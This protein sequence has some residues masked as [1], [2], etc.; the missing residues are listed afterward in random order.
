MAAIEEQNVFS[1]SVE[2]QHTNPVQLSATTF[3]VKL[4][5]A[6]IDSLHTDD[7]D[8]LTLAALETEL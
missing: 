3:I 6:T 1:F 5:K 7:V 4:L 8:I 2:I